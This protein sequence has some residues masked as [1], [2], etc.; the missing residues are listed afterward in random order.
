MFSLFEKS[1]IKIDVFVTK[2]GKFRAKIK[3]S[4]KTPAY[5]VSINGES[6]QNGKGREHE[7]RIKDK[8]E[9]IIKKLKEEY[10]TAWQA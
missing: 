2:G 8:C 4:K 9:R 7:E 5:E 6:W 3:E 10:A 1:K